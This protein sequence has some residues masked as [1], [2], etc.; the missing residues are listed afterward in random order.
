MNTWEWEWT[1]RN[2]EWFDGEERVADR[3]EQVG[4]IEEGVE[5]EGWEEGG[6]F[7]GGCC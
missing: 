2:D 7:V 1:R 4:K 6:E 3:D 5:E